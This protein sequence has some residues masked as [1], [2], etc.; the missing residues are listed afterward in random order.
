MTH[1]ALVSP[2]GSPRAARPDAAIVVRWRLIRILA[3]VPRAPVAL[4]VAPAGYGKSTLLAQ[5]AERDARPFAFVALSQADGD[6]GHLLGSIARA[7]A[8]VVP[9]E[10]ATLEGIERALAAA[11]PVVIVLD[12]LDVIGGRASLTAL[13]ALADRLPAGSQLALA[14]RGEPALPIARMRAQRRLVGLRARDL[15]MT[16]REAGVL[17]AGAGLDLPRDEVAALVRRAEGWPAVLALAVIAAQDEPDPARAIRGLA[18]ANRLVADYLRDEVLAGLGGSAARFLRRAS[19]LDVLSGAVCDATLGVSGSGALLLELSRANVPLVCLDDSDVEYRC[20]GLFA[21]MLRSE[22][23]RV[24]PDRERELHRRAAAWCAEQGDLNR[25][26]HHAVCAGDAATAGKL[27]WANA[28]GYLLRG[29]TTAVRAWLDG[30]GEATRA[31]VPGLALTAAAVHLVR[32][33]RDLAEHWTAAAERAFDAARGDRAEL[34]AGAAMLRAGVCREGLGQMAE[35]AA[36]ADALAAETSPWRGVSRLLMG[37]AA[38]LTG[39]PGPAGAHLREAARI[40]GVAAPVVQVL[41]LAQLAVLAIDAEDWTEAEALSARARSQVERVGL[42]D[43]PLAALAL[44]VSARVRAQR[45]RAEQA[46]ED[47]RGTLRLLARL[48][49]FAPWYTAE[50]R[51]VLAGA[52][53][54]LGDVATARSLVADATRLAREIPEAVVL[55]A[56]L[57]DLAESTESLV[58]SVALPTSLTTAE[59][60]VLQLLPTHLS[61]RE[62]AVGLHVSAN[63][64]KT[65]A[66]SVYR[67]LDASSRSEAVVRAREAGLLG[68]AGGDLQAPPASVAGRARPDSLTA[69]ELEVLRFLP[70]ELSFAEIGS[71]LRVSART[72]RTHAEAANRKLAACSRAEAVERARAFGLLASA[73][74]AAATP[75]ELPPAAR[76]RRGS[77]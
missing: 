68:D 28:G 47:R 9:I 4:V 40:G 63:T 64:V 23:R 50:V 73:A 49:D 15:A 67:K 37:V 36:R 12:D 25:A 24:E 8:E 26:V 77:A 44:A 31:A 27:L 16:R 11:G 43:A 22:L 74:R 32:G 5:W 46:R 54:R 7:L 17:L 18:G 61:F 72:V 34:E 21:Q 1:L 53:L 48:T 65:H 30:F 2:A 3:Q 52:T 19:V 71:R 20:H 29:R 66:H 75:A 69:A 59:L 39:E 45:G 38:H 41:S 10:E 58:E 42:E 60:R 6:A 14:A 13:A 55:G 62:M 51:A 70:S 56:W 57:A 35:S 33:E 76:P